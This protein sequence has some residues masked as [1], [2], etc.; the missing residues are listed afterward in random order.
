MEDNAIIA[1]NG[2]IIAHTDQG[3][4]ITL[5]NGQSLSLPKEPVD[6]GYTAQAFNLANLDQNLKAS[7]LN[8]DGFQT[9]KQGATPGQSM[10]PQ[11]FHPKRMDSDGF[12]IDIV[13]EDKRSHQ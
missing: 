12:E 5:P 7:G 2:N 13:A 3:T 8:R 9:L 1:P 11:T 6:W 10:K 4:M